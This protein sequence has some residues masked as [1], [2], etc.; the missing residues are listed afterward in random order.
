MRILV[1]NLKESMIIDEDIFNAQGSLIL[2]KGTP[3]NDKDNMIRLL[4]NNGINKIKVL[5]LDKPPEAVPTTV[6][7][8]LEEFYSVDSEKLQD[9]KSFLKDFSNSVSRFEEEVIDNLISKGEKAN[10]DHIMEEVL[11]STFDSSLNVFQLLQKIKNSD[12]ITFMHCNSVA[13]TAFTIGTWMKLPEDVLK[14]LSM[15]ALFADIGKFNIP[16]E[17]LTK[18]EPLT[19]SEFEIVKEHV[20]HSV[21]ILTNAKFKPDII[22]AVK[23]HHERTDGS[24]YPYRLKGDQIPTLSKIIAVADVFVAL[25]SKRP[26]RPKYTP[27]EALHIL[28]TDFMQ[29]LDIVI[30]SKFISKAASNYIG[31]PVRL[32]D[33]QLGE[34]LFINMNAPLRPIVKITQSK[35][36][37]DLSAKNNQEIKIE[38]FL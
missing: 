21:S 20:S 13:L 38:E 3:V 24:G 15:A 25:T 9:I 30:L 29:K 11:N 31:N 4:K 19:F 28:E 1:R 10:A 37:V 16:K 34:I 33:G 17:I 18:K 22:D 6:L 36:L 8:V 27:F 7:S 32:S 26:Y 23:F 14:D 35:D 12:D 5:S 2:S